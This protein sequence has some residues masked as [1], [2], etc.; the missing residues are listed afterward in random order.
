[1]KAD[2]IDFV[3]FAFGLAIST[4][5]A[6]GM[7]GWTGASLVWII[8]ILVLALVIE[9]L[10]NAPGRWRLI[11]LGSFL[12]ITIGVVLVTYAARGPG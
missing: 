4:I 5:A 1:M 11:R 2:R 9:N 12:G 7:Y 6:I 10:P 8:G 3:A